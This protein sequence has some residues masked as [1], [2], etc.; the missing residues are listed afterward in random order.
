MPT[1]GEMPVTAID[2]PLFLGVDQAACQEI[3]EI[4]VD[5]VDEDRDRAVDAPED[6]QKMRNITLERG[7]IGLARQCQQIGE[8][9]AGAAQMLVAH[10]LV[11]RR[12]DLGAKAQVLLDR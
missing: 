1:W 5:V 11:E 6:R 8:Q 9:V 4:F 3:L 10:H 12:T 7:E 2:R